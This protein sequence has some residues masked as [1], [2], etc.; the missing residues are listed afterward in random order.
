MEGSDLPVSAASWRISAFDI[1]NG[2]GI[3]VVT[4]RSGKEFTGRVNKQLSMNDVLH[5][6]TDVGWH[7]IDWT[8]I[9]AITGRARER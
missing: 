3:A 1:A 8:E 4:L 9:A 6:N 2:N 5:L 7:T